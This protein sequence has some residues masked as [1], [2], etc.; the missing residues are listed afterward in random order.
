VLL[1][2]EIQKYRST[3][4]GERLNHALNINTVFF[5]KDSPF[6]VNIKDE[7]KNQIRRVLT[8]GQLNPLFTPWEGLYDAVGKEVELLL[9]DSFMRFKATWQF[10]EVQRIL[11][12]TW[13]RGNVGISRKQV[14]GIL[15]DSS[16]YDYAN[17]KFYIFP[18]TKT[19]KSI[20]SEVLDYMFAKRQNAQTIQTKKVDVTI[21]TKSEE[22][23]GISFSNIQKN[24]SEI[25]TKNPESVPKSP[26]HQS[27]IFPPSPE[28][29]EDRFQGT[30]TTPTVRSTGGSDPLIS[31]VNVPMQENLFARSFSLTKSPDPHGIY[32]SNG[33]PKIFKGDDLVMDVPS[34]VPSPDPCTS[35]NRLVRNLE[36][37]SILDP[38]EIDLGELGSGE[39][40]EIT[41]NSKFSGLIGI[42][43]T[44]KAKLTKS[45]SRKESSG[46]SPP[47]NEKSFLKTVKQSPEIK[48]LQKCGSTTQDFS[49]TRVERS[50]MTGD[51]NPTTGSSKVNTPEAEITSEHLLLQNT[52]DD[53]PPSL[54]SDQ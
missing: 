43:K 53:K 16:A 6:E 23:D 25:K 39:K 14:K 32:P 45:H 38:K 34:P 17:L 29:S 10:E 44:I 28:S 37:V 24:I 49:F 22:K 8:Q 19:K 11:R 50:P 36:D 41:K 9:K 52:K 4:E 20:S 15:E 40:G 54:K 27:P 7:H 48:L 35:R 47:V 3:H 42:F 21:S 33:S 12:Q 2:E 13:L 26:F 30:P 18:P 5:A 31:S 1:L 46:N 51:I